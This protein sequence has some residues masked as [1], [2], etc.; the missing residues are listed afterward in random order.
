VAASRRTADQALGQIL[1]VAGFGQIAGP[2]AAG[3][4]AQL[5]G[6]RIGLLALPVLVVLAAVTARP[7]PRA[8][9]TG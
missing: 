4:I 7:V 3:A 5:A 2:L 1:T 8:Q 9:R 6:L